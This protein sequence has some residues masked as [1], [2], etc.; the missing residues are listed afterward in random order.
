MSCVRESVIRPLVKV[1]PGDALI[2][3]NWF[4]GAMNPDFGV[5]LHLISIG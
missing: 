4:S 3:L 1:V 5:A 2:A